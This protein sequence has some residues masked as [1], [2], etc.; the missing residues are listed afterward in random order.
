[1]K[2]QYYIQLV[3]GEGAT[4]DCAASVVERSWVVRVLILDSFELCSIYFFAC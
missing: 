3:I 1:M 2:S 4:K